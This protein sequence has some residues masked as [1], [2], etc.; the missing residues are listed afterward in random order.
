MQFGLEI[1]ICERELPSMMSSPWL[2]IMTQVILICIP[3]F[4][5]RNYVCSTLVCQQCKAY[6]LESSLEEIYFP[7][8]KDKCY[9]SLF[10]QAYLSDFLRD[11]DG[12]KMRR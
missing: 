5:K 8:A 7:K 1:V 11:Q 6:I 3:K 4:H 12:D 2:V 9:P 10:L